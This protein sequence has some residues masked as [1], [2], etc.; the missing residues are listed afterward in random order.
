MK[1]RR[2]YLL[3][4]SVIKYV[5]TQRLYFEGALRVRG[6]N[7]TPKELVGIAVR[8]R[9]DM[10]DSVGLMVCGSVC[11]KPTW[12]YWSC[13]SGCYPLGLLRQD[14][15]LSRLS[16]H[17]ALKKHQPTLETHVKRFMGHKIGSTD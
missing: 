14:P 8:S 2:A 3:H 13:Y 15:E 10:A 7:T 16:V 12:S 5:K 9:I 1:Q 6:R 4:L 11:R 17:C